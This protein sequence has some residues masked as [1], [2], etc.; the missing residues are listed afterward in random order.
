AWSS[1]RSLPVGSVEKNDSK[2]IDN[3][4]GLSAPAR[5]SPICLLSQY[6]PI[7]YRLENWGQA[8]G[9]GVGKVRPIR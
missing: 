4:P 8:E 9:S 1:R 2:C 5:S 3:K 7:S 6:Q